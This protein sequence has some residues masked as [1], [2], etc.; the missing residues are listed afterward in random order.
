MSALF[1]ISSA[2]PDGLTAAG[3]YEIF[4]RPE[5]TALRNAYG[6]KFRAQTADATGVHV[7]DHRRRRR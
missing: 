4:A 2:M 5:W 7:Q 3:D 6:L 1:A